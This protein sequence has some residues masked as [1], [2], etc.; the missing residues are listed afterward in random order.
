MGPESCCLGPVLR[1]HHQD[2]RFG[3]ETACDIR[4]SV[5]DVFGTMLSSFVA[6]ACLKPIDEIL[7]LEAPC[8]CYF[9]DPAWNSRHLS[10][11][12]AAPSGTLE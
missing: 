4:G 7:F 1:H 12:L 2:Q 10:P 6:W 9:T 3:G 11:L 5:F 8:R